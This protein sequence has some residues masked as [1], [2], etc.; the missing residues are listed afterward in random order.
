MSWKTIS[1]SKHLW[2]SR[3]ILEH[4]WIFD[5]VLWIDTKL[6][7]DPKLLETTTIPEFARSRVKILEYFT[8]LLSIIQASH[9]SPRLKQK[10]IDML[11]IDEPKWLSIWYW[12]KRDSWSAISENLAKQIILSALETLH[13]WINNPELIELLGLFVDDFWPDRMS[14]L[15]SYIIYEDLCSFTQ[16]LSLELWIET[17]IFDI[18][19]LNYNLPGHPFRKNTPIILLPIEILRELPVATSWEDIDIVAKKNESLRDEWNIFTNKIIVNIL[20]RLKSD[21]VNLDK[22]KSDFL[23]LVRFY[24]DIQVDHYDI[25]TDSKWCYLLS[26]FVDN[27]ESLFPGISN[28]EPKNWAE[29]IEVVRDFL[30]QF[31]RS[32]EDN[33]WNNLLYHRT[34]TGSI[35][36][37]K[38]HHEDVAQR[39]FYMLADQYCK[40]YNIMIAGESY[41]GRWPVDFSLWTWYNKKVLVEIKKGDNHNTLNGF[42][43]QLWAYKDSENAIYGFY[44]V[45]ELWPYT[46]NNK[47]IA[48][49]NQEFPRWKNR[50]GTSEIF[51]VDWR[52]YPPPSKL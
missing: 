12:D 44:V 2:V 31:K 36:E 11:A 24:K 22:A 20:S 4:N 41:A 5:S 45:I 40:N 38:F 51:Y 27:Q 16:R 46:E 48:D 17:K 49:L 47:A 52:I 33:G 13:V 29:L 19:W 26:P 7:I 39:L 1:L 43:N 42:E 35:L 6:F 18:D 23:N 30:R 9:E 21:N 28:R 8:R 14:D 37:R 32:I 34:D 15:A 10:S 3:E 25:A 50:D